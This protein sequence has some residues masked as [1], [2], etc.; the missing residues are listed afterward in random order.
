MAKFVISPRSNG[1]YQF[2][3]KA[4]NG[5]PIL[6]SEG[7]TTKANCNNGIA[8]VKTH[9]TNASNYEKKVSSNSKYYFTLK[10]SNGQ[11]I[12]TSELYE[13]TAGRDNGIDSVMQH[14][15]KAEVE[16]KTVAV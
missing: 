6:A 4:S 3:L 12:G 13:T 5:E 9:S 2:V 16:D 7:Y 1:E 14:A 10:A 15:P 11:V 8:S